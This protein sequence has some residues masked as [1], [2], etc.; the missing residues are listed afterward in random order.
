[1][2]NYILFVLVLVIIFHA[3]QPIILHA[4]VYE[5]WIARYHYSIE[6]ANDLAVDKIGNVYVTGTSG[7]YIDGNDCATV[8]YDS[9]GREIWVKRYDAPMLGGQDEAKAIELD[10]AGN[11]YVAGTSYDGHAS[12]ED[13]L[14][15]KYDPVGN[16]L[17]TKL[18]SAGYDISNWANDLILDAAGNIY[19]TGHMHYTGSNNDYLTVKYDNGGRYLLR[20]QYDGPG[21]W[22]D[23]AKFVR[24]DSGGNV[25][26]TG[27]SCDTDKSPD[28]TTIKYDKDGVEL[29][30]NRYSH[31]YSAEYYPTGMVVDSHGNV[32]VTGYFI[33]GHLTISTCIT[34][35]YSNAGTELWS[36][37]YSGSGFYSSAK[38]NDIAVDNS[39]NVY[40]TGVS[41]VSGVDSDYTTIKY[42]SVG[43]EIWV[44]SYNGPGSAIDEAC[45]IV[46]DTHGNS[47]VTGMSEGIGTS[48][49]YATVKYDS[50]GNEL[51]SIRYDGPDHEND[52]A[53][54]MDIDSAENIYITGSSKNLYDHDYITIKLVQ[55]PVPTA[56]PTPF[57]TSTPVI[58]ITPTPKPIPVFS[59]IMCVC[60]FSSLMAMCLLSRR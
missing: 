38:S 56:S 49:D 43:N 27:F 9:S 36:K 19:I 23:R 5:E 33:T 25:Y 7:N 21:N 18:Y 32:Y 53:S 30:I 22:N 1:M 17:W 45:C 51:W 3:A 40:I 8:K 10:S 29:W 31:L 44:A 58:T 11:I 54:A 39:G 41:S 57:K 6:N 52:A 14:L 37:E 46:L 13:Y 15:I 60:L 59:N 16:E 2:K 28:I 42:D 34:L 35:K 48:G 12:E 55:G 24:V 47:Y 50:D 4:Q 20:T 26:V